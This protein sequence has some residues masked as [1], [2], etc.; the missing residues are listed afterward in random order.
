MD[1][2]AVIFDRDG[3]LVD[4]DLEAAAAY[5]GPLVPVSLEQ[6]T[7]LWRDYGQQ[8]GFPRTVDEERAF[9]HGVW[10][11]VAQALELDAETEARL[12][13]FEY[14]SILYA[15]PDAVPALQLCRARGLRTAVL[16]NF[17]LASIEASLAATGL[18]PLVDVAAAATV[19]GA[20]KPDPA[21]YQYVLQQ[22]DVAPEAC[23]LFDNKMQHVEGARRLGMT[24]Y[25]LDRSAD[26]H[27]VERGVI[28]DLFVVERVLGVGDRRLEIG[29]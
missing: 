15:Y 12:Q 5:F 13:Q 28:S 21:A 29:D 9:W 2:E 26:E 10:Q 1:Y 23:V 14:T 24:A 17:S 18:A 25:L 6:L 4:F 8:Q 11:Y 7:A 27:D 3:V 20:A 19:I 22:L 16:S